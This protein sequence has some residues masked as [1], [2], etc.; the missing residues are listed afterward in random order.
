[1]RPCLYRPRTEFNTRPDNF[2]G[3][4][5]AHYELNAGPPV[6]H[7]IRMRVILQYSG[8]P[9]LAERQG[10]TVARIGNTSTEKEDIL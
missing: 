3:F 1:M 6:N 9:G 7:F 2:G 8:A 4:K 10:E 5:L